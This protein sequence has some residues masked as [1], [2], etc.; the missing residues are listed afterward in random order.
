MAF[1]LPAHHRIRFQR[2]VY[3]NGNNL[4]GVASRVEILPGFIDNT[5]DRTADQMS[6]GLEKFDGLSD[7]EMVA[8]LNPGQLP[9]CIIRADETDEFMSLR[10]A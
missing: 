7:F 1:H 3:R 9:L 2:L 5:A 4:L 8:L 10:I 6:L